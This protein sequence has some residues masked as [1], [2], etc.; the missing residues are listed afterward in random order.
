M[1]LAEIVALTIVLETLKQHLWYTHAY[2][3]GM[4]GIDKADNTLQ[5][6]ITRVP[7]LCIA[8]GRFLFIKELLHHSMSQVWAA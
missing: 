5:M 7:C 8:T 3:S 1:S 2:I 4:S 6:F